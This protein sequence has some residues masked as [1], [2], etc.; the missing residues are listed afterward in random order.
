VTPSSLLASQTTKPGATARK[1]SLHKPLTY[2][3]LFESISRQA[4]LLEV[5]PQTAA[6]RASALRIFMKVHSLHT[7]DVVGAELRANFSTACS[8]LG[9]DLHA[10]GR[11]PRDVSNTV[12]MLRRVHEM[13]LAADR[14]SAASQDQLAPFTK[15]VRA[16]MDEQAVKRVARQAGIPVDML[17]GWLKGKQPRPSNTRYLTRLESFFGIEQSTFAGLAGVSGGVRLPQQVGVP[18]RNTYRERLSNQSRARFFFAPGPESP[19][20]LQWTA[21][22]Q[23]KTEA[24]PSTLV[25][26]PAG[27]WT[28]SPVA[29]KQARASNWFTFLDGKEVPSANVNWN[30][31]AGYL[32][33]LALPVT[34]GGKAIAADELNTL[35][36]FAL[37]DWIEEYLSWR[38]ARSG[39]SHSR[40]ILTFLGLLIWLT[41][42]GDG[43]LFQL[44]EMMGTLPERF[45]RGTW[46]DMCER[47]HT[48]C[49][50]L[51][52]ALTAEAVTIRDPFAPVRPMLDQEQP[53]DAIADMI[54]R[55]RLARPC[56]GAP[57]S[58]AIWARDIFLVKLLASNPLRLR[59]LACLVWEPSFVDGYHR[60]DQPCLYKKTDGSWWIFISRTLLKNRR[61]TRVVKDYDAPIHDSAWRDLERYLFKHRNV[62][63]C[64]PTN[65]VFLTRKRD[66]NKPHVPWMEIVHTINLLTK[67]YLWKCNG[68]G[69][70]AFR[71]I[72]ATAILKAPLGTT[73]TAAL[74]L[75]DKESTVEAA[76]SGLVSRDGNEQMFKLLDSSF[77]RMR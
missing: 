19:L 40:H 53:L 7:H 9:S 67:R 74:V 42:P 35:A 45:Q 47:Q 44:P 43:Y 3:Q 33:F 55:M 8:A 20:R 21:L 75:N 41:R 24:V 68:V 18:P 66:K 69:P 17:Y 10:D 5:K 64:S 36:W 50:K 73:K 16:V 52:N 57:S 63:M 39:G 27:R 70:H 31:V 49:F 65:L 29:A 34:A 54:S 25:R 6:N 2:D 58:E 59:N 60:L 26:G 23:Y 38:K 51:R 1:K 76:Y 71:H 30:H 15:A 77:K 61:G 32:G 62:L 4:S 48:Y 22:L 11:S 13:V 14:V 46:R 56:G 28:F 72:V 37:P 12:S